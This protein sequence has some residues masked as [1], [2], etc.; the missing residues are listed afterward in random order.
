MLIEPAVTEIVCTPDSLITAFA[1]IG[2]LL[3]LSKILGM[4]GVFNE[5]RFENKLARRFGKKKKSENVDDGA[6]TT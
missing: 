2:G 6:T 1:K 3:G 4:L 5:W